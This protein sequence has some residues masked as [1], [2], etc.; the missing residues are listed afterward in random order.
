M[1]SSCVESARNS[2]Y[3][4]RNAGLG[5]RRIV[6]RSPLSHSNSQ[7]SGTVRLRILLLVLSVLLFSTGAFGQS[8]S[9]SSSSTSIVTSQATS[10]K[11]STSSSSSITTVKATGTSSSAA[12]TSTQKSTDEGTV[13]TGTGE[14]P[15]PFDT[16]MG[17]SITSATC[18]AFFTLFLGDP[19]FRKCLPLSAM[20]QNSKSF[21]DITKKSGFA[22][23][24]VLDSSCSADFAK[25]STK[26]Q[27]YAKE[28][29]TDARC[30]AEIAAKNQ[31]AVQ[32]YAAFLA[33]PALF[34]AG[35][36]KSDT[37]SYCYVDAVT[38]V[39]S[40]SDSHIYF[41][42]LGIKLPGGSRPTCSSCT[43]ETM[44]IFQEYAGSSGQPL[45][46]TYMPAAQLINMAC[47]PQFVNTTVTVNSMAS[48]QKS[49]QS[50]LPILLT[51]AV[52]LTT[53]FFL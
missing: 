10:S 29:R 14:L 2:G 36:L 40:P 9:T 7:R 27:Y 16:S 52:L 20:L 34:K 47:G 51:F 6:N 25:C 11:A 48:N 18:S 41:L 50:T 15:V 42:P 3:K 4:P 8:T 31:L 26:M 24:R 37:G 44:Q 46:N 33:Y 35:C 43:Q 53:N 13:V 28:I 49:I 12:P 39:T 30:G 19:E 5:K 45:H 23:T 32:A 1:N 21:F 22:T 17:K 38:N